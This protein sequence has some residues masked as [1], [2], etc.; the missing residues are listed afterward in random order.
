MPRTAARL[1]VACPHTSAVMPAARSFPKRSG[2]PS[3]TRNPAT[4]NAANAA[5]TESEPTSPSSSPT[6]AKIMSVCASG[7]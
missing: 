1:I 4:A 5:I 6:T 3:A 7:R 2:Q